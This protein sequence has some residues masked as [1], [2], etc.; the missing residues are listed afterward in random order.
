[1]AESSVATA[2]SFV[3]EPAPWPSDHWWKDFGDLQLDQLIEEAL[4]NSPTV[5]QAAGRIRVASAQS[6]LARASLLPKVGATAT[7]RYSRITQ[8]IG[9][10]T[11]GDWH[12]LGA[13]LIN[14]SYDL[15]LWGKNRSA[16]RAAVSEQRANEADAAAAR[17]ALSVA[18]ASSY[19]DLSQLYLRRSVAADALSVRKATLDLVTRRFNAGLDPRT[20]L[21]QAQA[22]ADAATGA[23]A[24]IDEAIG[25]N[26]NA[27]AA[28]L[29]AGPDRGLDIKVPALTTRRP[30]G[31]PSDAAI[32][33]IGRNP[34]V[35]SA[36]WR[37]EAE[38]QR[39][40]VAKAGFYPD[41]SIAGLIGVASFGLSNL[42]KQESIIGSAGPAISLPI[43][44]GG[45][46]AANYRGA[47]ARYDI[48]VAQYDEAL[49]RALH[50][51]AD[52]ATSERALAARQLAADGAVTRQEAAY[53]LARMR[54]EGGLA[55]YQSVLIVEDSLLNARDQAASLR[56]RGFVLD[57][58]LVNALGGGFRG[59]LPIPKT[60]PSERA[61][62]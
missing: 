34:D 16:L 40:G 25:V 9:L 38:A 30:F 47:R 17:L 54:Y 57:I 18:V 15:D 41:V 62:S 49:L 36:R 44:D 23:L 14:A 61:G 58:A 45:R 31:L 6:D 13:G 22:G 55:D 48:A 32:N 5:E 21:E 19:S 7:A 39:I 3:A 11:D 1:M 12:L 28:L 60:T 35:V 27:L 8:S 53:R 51:V 29:G 50:D 37:V 33:L 2:R 46:L 10:P 42:F 52:A 4:A 20:A 56:L 43:F 24:A 26:R 59:D